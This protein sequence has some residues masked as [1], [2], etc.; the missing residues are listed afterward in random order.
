MTAYATPDDVYLLGLS[1]QGFVVRPRPVVATDVNTATGTIRLKAHGLD[2][3]DLITFEVVSGG[4][5]PAE[6]AGF[7][8]NYTSPVVVGTD[9]LKIASVL[10]GSTPIASFTSA[11]S[12][13]G[14][15]VDGLRRL[16]RHLVA[17][18][19]RLD[20]CLTAHAPPLKVDPITG[21]YHPEA[22]AL[23]A[24]MAARA[25]V[26]SLQIENAGARKAV[27]RLFAMEERDE[28]RLL[29]LKMGMP[30]NPRPID[31]DVVPNNAPRAN[32]SC[33][34]PWRRNYL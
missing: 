16:T 11:G 33:L 3:A 20:G 22:I 32:G 19:A 23:N 15:T 25:A 6:L 27:D 28:A 9:L 30:L 31:Q 8:W 7:G 2:A 24:R 21:A 12:G 34:I 1:A 10:G 26:I 17:E 4:S 14:I 5:L 29:E 18:A 13:W